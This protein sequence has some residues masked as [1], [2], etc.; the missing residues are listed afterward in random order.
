MSTSPPPTALAWSDANTW[1]PEHTMPDGYF[2]RA[3]PYTICKIGS[4]DPT[5]TRTLWRFEIW[6]GTEYLAVRATLPEAR[7]YAERHHRKHG[8]SAVPHDRTE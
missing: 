6:H 1:D 7:R 3:D 2:I 5:S 8:S 4:A